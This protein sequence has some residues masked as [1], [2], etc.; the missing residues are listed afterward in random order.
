MQNPWKELIDKLDENYLVPDNKYIIEEDLKI[1]D[2]FNNSFK[3][4]K[5]KKLYEIHYEV[6]PSHY[7]GNIRNAEVVILATNP[8]YVLSEVDTLYKNEIFHKE[9]IENLTFKTKTFLI[10]D[11]K[12]IE[13]GDYWYKRTE[14]LREI[15]GDQNVLKKIALLQFFPYHSMK[16]RK[17]A[18][19]YFE[20]GE[21][22]LKTQK[23]GFELLREAIHENKLII[24]SRS[25]VAW[26]KAVPELKIYKQSGNVIE[27]N[28]Y[29]QPYLTPGNMD[30][31]DFNKLV[32]KLISP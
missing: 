7:T 8:G 31:K 29:R 12:R 1:V 27:L 32:E 11:K 23:F 22:Y 20:N 21:E 19:K 13:Q 4:K 10:I 6:H 9:K 16:Y 15:V 26:Y 14:K 25:K 2:R 5:S 28:N 3:S 30:D 18:K 24:I 17:I